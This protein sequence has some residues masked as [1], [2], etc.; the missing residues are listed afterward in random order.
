MLQY[1]YL[2]KTLISR[3]D[4]FRQVCAGCAPRACEGEVLTA[5]ISNRYKSRKVT[6]LVLGWLAG[7]L[8][9]IEAKFWK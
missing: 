1:L 7:W 9:C 8:G 2:L 6:G 5:Q 4:L 3:P